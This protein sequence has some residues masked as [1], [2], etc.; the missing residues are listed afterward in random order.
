M[1]GGSAQFIANATL[2]RCETRLAL[3][4]VRPEAVCTVTA[5]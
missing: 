4:V 3:T 5:V 2:I 1:S